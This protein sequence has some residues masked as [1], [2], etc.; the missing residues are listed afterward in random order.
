[1]YS[2]NFYKILV[3]KK[4][5][6]KNNKPSIENKSKSVLMANKNNLFK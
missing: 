1:M 4:K 3:Q 5:Y 2:K 6:T